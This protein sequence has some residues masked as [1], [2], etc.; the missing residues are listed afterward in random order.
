MIKFVT[1]AALTAFASP[2]AAFP[3]S[4]IFVSECMLGEAC[5]ETSF[6]ASVSADGDAGGKLFLTTGAETLKGSNI[7]NEGPAHLFFVGKTAVHLITVDLA[8]DGQNDAAHYTVHMQGPMTISYSG[9]CQGD[10]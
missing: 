3:L 9:T 8:E 6:S 10:K 1:T 7:Q 2:I 4:C 5:E